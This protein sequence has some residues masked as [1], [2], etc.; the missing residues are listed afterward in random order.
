MKKDRRT[1]REP[2]RSYRD[3]TNSRGKIFEP[4]SLMRGFVIV[5]LNKPTNVKRRRRRGGE[6]QGGPVLEYFT[7]KAGSCP[8]KIGSLSN[9]PGD[10]LRVPPRLASSCFARTRVRSAPLLHAS[11]RHRDSR[12]EAAAAQLGH[13]SL[14]L[15]D[16]EK[17]FSGPIATRISFRFCAFF[18]LLLLFSPFILIARLSPENLNKA[19]TV[20]R[21]LVGPPSR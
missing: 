8:E 16:H 5:S 6:G 12:R 21:P 3:T 13:L 7:R 19:A 4:V 9:Y 10:L 15:T 20:D 17:Y 14:L 2:A 1:S 11:A 18:P